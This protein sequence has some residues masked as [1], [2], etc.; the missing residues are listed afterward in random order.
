MAAWLSQ[1]LAWIGAFCP[2]ECFTKF[3]CSVYILDLVTKGVSMF[4]H[5]G[6]GPGCFKDPAGLAVDRLYFHLMLILFCLKIYILVVSVS[7]TCWWRTAGTT[8]CVST[9]QMADSWQRSGL[10]DDQVEG[11]R[12]TLLKNNLLWLIPLCRSNWTLPQEGPVDFCWIKKMETCTC[13]IF[14][15]LKFYYPL[16]MFCCQGEAAVMRYSLQ[17]E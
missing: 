4:G 12:D 1:I 8:D 16:P 11:G 5:S 9:T 13:W 15:F 6:S 17:I 3:L 2:N 14:R 10:T 7:G